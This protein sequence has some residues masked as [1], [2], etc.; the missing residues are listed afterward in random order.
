[1]WQCKMKFL[2]RDISY[3]PFIF[4]RTNEN[5]SFI[6]TETVLI[7]Q[8]LHQFLSFWRPIET[9]LYMGQNIQEWSK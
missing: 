9:E 8:E 7:G 6:I 3:W 4:T 1:M 5:A 2:I